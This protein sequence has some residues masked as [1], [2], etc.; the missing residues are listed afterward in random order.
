MHFPSSPPTTNTKGRR[1]F[2]RSS[3]PREFVEEQ[4]LLQILVEKEKGKGIG[5][6]MEA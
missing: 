4:S 2:T 1:P 3:V 5:N 6:P